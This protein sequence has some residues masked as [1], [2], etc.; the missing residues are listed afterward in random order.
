MSELDRR[1]HFRVDDMLQSI[2]E[3]EHSAF[4]HL[5]ADSL[6]E[7]F[8]SFRAVERNL[9]ILAEAS[10]HLPEDIKAANAQIDWMKVVNLR[11]ILAHDYGRVDHETVWK[12]IKNRLPELKAVLEKIK[13]CRS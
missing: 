10:K 9:E 6:R 2:E 8:E 12:V 3:I 13:G 11:N 4:D 7:D 1:W 5:D